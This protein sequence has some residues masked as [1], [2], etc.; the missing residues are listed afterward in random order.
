M[1]IEILNETMLHAWCQKIAMPAG[2]VDELA[3][4]A[5][6][7]RDDSK[8]LALFTAFHKQTAV[9]GDWHTSWDPLPFDPH[10]TQKLGKQDVLFYLLAYLAA[11]P[12][13][14]Q[15]YREMGIGMDI[16]CATMADISHYVQQ[17]Q[18]IQGYW[19]FDHFM[20]IWRHLTCRLFRLGR[21]QY[22]LVNYNDHASAYRSKSTGEVVMLCGADIPL[23]A[24]GFALGAGKKSD[25]PNQA[26]EDPAWVTTF[27][28]TPD[29]W[30]GNPISPYGYAQDSIIYLSREDWEPILQ[31]GD[32]VIDLHIPRGH[33]LTRE[34]LRASLRL[35]FDFFNTHT[36]KDWPAQPFKACYCHTWFFTPQ[37]QNS[38]ATYQQYC[39]LPA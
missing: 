21:L 18:D 27:Q 11:L 26:A 22:M 38:L 31:P 6:L 7:I 34:D 33:D 20:W 24:D 9:Q 32:T 17:A 29:G 39:S 2:A 35:A 25:Q 12:Y 4:V 8:L 23:R 14:E 19:T 37:L 15:S 10:V 16:F 28:E 5:G 30:S 1:E 36:A 13:T 3:Q